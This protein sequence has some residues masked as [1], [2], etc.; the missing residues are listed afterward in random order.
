MVFCVCVCRVFCISVGSKQIY[1]LL[2]FI[3]RWFCLLPIR[4]VLGTWDCSHSL[5][6]MKMH[7]YD[8]EKVQ[9]RTH[10]HTGK[11]SADDDRW[12]RLKRFLVINVF[13]VVVA[14]DAHCESEPNADNANA[15]WNWKK[16]RKKK[17]RAQAPTINCIWS[18]WKTAN[19]CRILHEH[20]AR[21][22]NTLNRNDQTI[23]LANA[24][25]ER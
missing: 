1:T 16:R 5:K 7:F 2:F 25:E 21:R 19:N 6:F 12:D 4:T 15:I 20:Q 9:I 14:V 3:Y 22:K 17:L 13:F 23:T 24:L 10:T 8:I 18:N 11:E